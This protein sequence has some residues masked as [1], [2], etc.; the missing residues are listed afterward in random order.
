MNETPRSMRTFPAA[1][2]EQVTLENM[3]RGPFNRWAFRN[4]RRMLPT[5]NV[6]RGDGPVSALPVR[7]VHLDDIAFEDA[8]GDTLTVKRVLDEGYTDGFVALH[9]GEIVAERYGDGVEAHEPHLLMSVTKSFAGTLAGVLAER[10]LVSPDDRVTDIVPEVAG[11][12]YDGALVRHVLD[13]TVGMDYDEDYDNPAS[14]VG[15]L[16]VASGWRPYREGA[17]D[18]LRDYI[19]TMRPAGE[20]GRVFHYVSTNTD[21]LGWILERVAGTDFATLLGREIWRPMGAE[22]DAYIALDRL[23]AP[24][25]DGGLC[26]ATRDLARFGQ[27]HLRNGVMNGRRVAPESWIRDFR[28]NGDAEAW[29]RGNFAETMPGCHY[30]SKWYTDLKDDNRPFFGI[31]V[32]GQMLFVDPAAGV[33][34]AKHSSHPAP[35]DEKFFDDMKR[36]FKAVARE[37]GGRNVRS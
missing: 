30:R 6:W 21:L 37:L 7:P 15:L 24:Q 8:R 20:H 28:E 10:G 1:P 22:F 18:N 13:M 14:D 29:D 3:Q 27:L 12:A 35:V 5:A 26:V 25:T 31:G 11:S 2:G 16:D 23:G 33:V 36:A 19:A 32:H 34:C 9:R 17:P 4:M